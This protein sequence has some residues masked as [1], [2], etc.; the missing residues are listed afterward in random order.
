MPANKILLTLLLMFP[1]I[2]FWGCDEGNTDL[3]T[4]IAIP[5]SVEE[6][7]RKNIREY[8]NS[9]GTVY[10]AKEV[11]LKLE[12]SGEYNLKINPRTGRKFAAG[13]KVNKGEV[14][15]RIEDQE[16]E[17]SIQIESKKLN[18]EISENEFEKQ[19]SLYEKGGVTYRELK[20]SEIE[21]INAKYSYEQAVIQLDKMN[22]KA[23]FS[24]I[25]VDLPYFTEGVKV[26]SSEVVAEIM[27][28]SKL[29]MELSLPETEYKNVKGNMDIVVTNYSLPDDTLAGVLEKVFPSIDSDT[30]TFK[31]S[32][33][34]DNPK[35]VLLPGM[36]VKADIISSEKENV[37][38]IPKEVIQ[39]RQRGRTVYIV[40]KNFAV[41]KIIETGL[42]NS[43]EAEVLSGLKEGQR[44][45]VKG[46]ESLRNRS[47]VK[48]IK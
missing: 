42:E 31:V 10:A 9:T 28:Y 34:V 37:I 18:M 6:I 12:M 29:Y 36:F 20:N 48:V 47:K 30:R 32:V 2:L 22:I 14:I 17:N 1:V 41:E 7:A 26:E 8:I 27:N 33:T 24:G 19:K 35:L 3:S 4:Q 23:P 43:D 40:D 46:F 11:A 44:L 16:Y 45:I 15:I 5:V 39:S 38:V 25:I 21:F 13:D